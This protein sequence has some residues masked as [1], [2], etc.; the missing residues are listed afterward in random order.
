MLK[1]K[2]NFKKI[3]KYKKFKHIKS[4]K[5]HKTQNLVQN[6]EKNRMSLVELSA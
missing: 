5:L 2:L 4:N 3:A 6:Y 1:C